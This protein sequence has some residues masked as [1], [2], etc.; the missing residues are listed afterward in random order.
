MDEPWGRT[1]SHCV[2]VTCCSCEGLAPTRNAVVKDSP[3]HA[4][5]LLCAGGPHGPPVESVSPTVSSPPGQAFENHHVAA[6]SAADAAGGMVCP[7]LTRVGDHASRY[8]SILA[9]RTHPPPRG[10]TVGYVVGFASSATAPATAAWDSS[11]NVLACSQ[12]F[13]A[14]PT[15]IPRA[16]RTWHSSA[17][18]SSLT[19]PDVAQCLLS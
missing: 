5:R 7:L 11:S 10:V 18:R 17:V 2:T 13:P 9:A 19:H 8:L 1:A 14:W 12:R 4:F 15:R 3:P 16:G 6:A